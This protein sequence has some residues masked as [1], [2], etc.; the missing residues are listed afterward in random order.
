MNVDECHVLYNRFKNI[1]FSTCITK[2][3]KLFVQNKTK[4]YTK[5]I[6]IIKL[7]KYES[8]F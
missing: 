8:T 5:L 2:T 3:F 4:Y 6:I 1:F 7:K